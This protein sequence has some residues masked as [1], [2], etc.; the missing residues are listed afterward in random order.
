[1]HWRFEMTTLVQTSGVRL[2]TETEI[3]DVNGGFI[4]LAAMGLIFAAE[5]GIGIGAA[6]YYG[7]SGGGENPLPAYG[8]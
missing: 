2:L 1:M 3:D 6:L 5:V 4:F 8:T 7:L